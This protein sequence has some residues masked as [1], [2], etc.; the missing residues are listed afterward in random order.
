[1]RSP[2]LILHTAQTN[3]IRSRTG[4]RV[5]DETPENEV[6]P[7]I[8]MGALISRDWSDKFVPGQEVH[9]TIHIW[10]QYAGKTEVLIIGDEV[11]QALTRT[12]LNLGASFHAVIDGG[13]D[14]HQVITD[15]DGF[16]RHGILTF[17]YLIEERI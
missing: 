11:L 2:F 12:P 4:R 3:R 9:S 13:F 10:S 6:F 7:Y 15:I 14:E 17:R 5:F 8:V 1:M 16:T